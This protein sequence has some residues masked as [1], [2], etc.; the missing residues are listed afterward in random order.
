MSIH[1]PYTSTSCVLLETPPTFPLKINYV[2]V[3]S[4]IGFSMDSQVSFKPSHRH[5]M[6]A[7]VPYTSTSCVLVENS[8]TF[9]LKINYVRLWS[10]IGFSM[11][12]QVSFKPSHRHIMSAHVPYT[13]TSC[14]LV[15]NSPTFP[16]KINYVRLWS[17]IGFSMG[18]QVSFKP[19]HRHI[20]SAHVPYT[21]TSCV[22]LE[23][24]PTFPLKINYV[25]VWSLIGFSMDSQ[26]SFKPSHRHIMSAH[27]PYTSTSCVLV[28]NSPTFPLKINYVRLWSLIGFSMDSQVSFKPSH[29]HIMSAHVPYTSTSCVLVETPPTFPLKINYVRLWSLIGFSMDSQ[30]SFKPSHRHIMS[31][32]VPYT[33]TS[34]VLLETPPAFPLKINYVHVWS[35]IGFS[36]DSQV[37]FKPS[38]RHIMSAH[39]PYTST[40]SVLVETPPTFPLKINY[41]YINLV[42]IVKFLILHECSIIENPYY[43]RIS[44]RLYPYI[45]GSTQFRNSW[46]SHNS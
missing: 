30:V 45:P 37:S 6:S 44:C 24:P 29:R 39:V 15:E 41:V 43:G 4:L 31:A 18:S 19:S 26:V 2:H 33:S 46:P 7:H 36:M 22:L 10:L 40:S 11:G 17:L 8:P 5:I 38:H 23:T 13:S 28:E 35:L 1:V 12:S 3:W 16:L 34:C 27:V 25:H 20:M 14:V 21:S 42:Y 32:H 9:P